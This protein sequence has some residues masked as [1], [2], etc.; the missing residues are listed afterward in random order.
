MFNQKNELRRIMQG[1]NALNMLYVSYHYYTTPTAL[2]AE[3]GLAFAS[4][5]INFYTLGE[6]KDIFTELFG[7][8]ASAAYTGSI[9]TN[10]MNGTMQIPVMFGI[11]EAALLNPANIVISLFSSDDN[12][13]TDKTCKVC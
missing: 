1:F 5:L 9:L 6:N 11:W 10:A 12:K 3:N 4:S 2:L 8:Y 13:A 7:Q